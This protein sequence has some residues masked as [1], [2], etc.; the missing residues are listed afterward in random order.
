MG[1]VAVSNKLEDTIKEKDFVQKI[2]RTLPTHFDT[3][4]LV[5][6]GISDLDN[7]TKD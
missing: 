3:K 6:E 1:S 5:L 7:L 2:V 4:V